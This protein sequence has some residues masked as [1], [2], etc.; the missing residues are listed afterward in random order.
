MVR[1]Y[2]R[3][4]IRRGSAEVLEVLRDTPNVIAT[5]SGQS[6]RNQ[7]NVLQGIA[8]I[9]NPAFAERHNAYRVFRVYDDRIEW[10]VRQ[11]ANRG[12][13]REAF[14]PDKAQ[15]W[16]ISTGPGD[17]AGTIPLTR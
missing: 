10:E 7:V 14:T 12:L 17:L 15:S 8:H 16:M 11:V 2:I 3:R 5:L 1:R 4:T 6:H 13:V 9:Q